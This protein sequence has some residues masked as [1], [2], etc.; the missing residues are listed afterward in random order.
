MGEFLFF[1]S[2]G[3]WA[4]KKRRR[5][6]AAS[7]GLPSTRWL[8]RRSGTHATQRSSASCR[9]AR[10]EED[11]GQRV[12]GSSSFSGSPP[13]P[14]QPRLVL[15]RP[16]RR[17]KRSRRTRPGISWPTRSR[18]GDASPREWCHG[19]LVMD[20]ATMGSRVKVAAQLPWGQLSCQSVRMRLLRWHSEACSG[21]WGATAPPPPSCCNGCSAR[22]LGRAP[23]RLVGSA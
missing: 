9:C 2:L 8:R 21:A 22:T 10:G 20:T 7:E 6:A 17:S 14:R 11:R 13:S 12:L 15:V 4:A 23:A 18:C 16:R 3:V 19:V 1:G 5:T